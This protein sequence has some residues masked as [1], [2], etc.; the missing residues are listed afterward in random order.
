MPF[1]FCSYTM[2]ITLLLQHFLKQRIII[3]NQIDE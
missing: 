3:G 2:K 1:I